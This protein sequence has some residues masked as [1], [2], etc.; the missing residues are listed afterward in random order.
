[1]SGGFTGPGF[2]LNYE[3]SVLTVLLAGEVAEPQ[4]GRRSQQTVRGNYEIDQETLDKALLRLGYAPTSGRGQIATIAQW[5]ELDTRAKTFG[6]HIT[7]AMGAFTLSVAFDQKGGPV[8]FEH[9]GDYTS[10]FSLRAGIS[11]WVADQRSKGML[12]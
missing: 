2:Y 12:L 3:R 6:L 5:Q 10:L 8:N 11:D 9:V 7:Y 4:P 1:M